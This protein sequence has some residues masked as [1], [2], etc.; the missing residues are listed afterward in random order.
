MAGHFHFLAGLRFLTDKVS[1]LSKISGL[2]ATSQ[3][4]DCS[5]LRE[6][7]GVT[8]Q[9]V[10]CL[11][12]WGS[13]GQFFTESSANGSKANEDKISSMRK[14]QKTKPEN[15]LKVENCPPEI[16]PLSSTSCL[17]DQPWRVQMVG[18]AFVCLWYSFLIFCMLEYENQAHIFISGSCW[19]CK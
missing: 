4:Q 8:E 5:T 7:R 14:L 15:P 1:C 10:T 2:L 12:C 19:K 11:A 3:G 9:W 17:P 18:W 16:P 13:T 6:V